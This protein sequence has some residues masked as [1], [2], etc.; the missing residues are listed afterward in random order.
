MLKFFHKARRRAVNLT[1]KLR[2]YFN[3][4]TKSEAILN[5]RRSEVKARIIRSRVKDLFLEQ[6]NREIS[7]FKKG[8]SNDKLYQ[9][10][11]E[12]ADKIA[13]RSESNVSNIVF[14]FELQRNYTPKSRK[15][16]VQA[17]LRVLK[18]FSR[19]LDKTSSDKNFNRHALVSACFKN[20]VELVLWTANELHHNYKRTNLFQALNLRF[21]NRLICHLI[22]AVDNTPSDVKKMEMLEHLN[23]TYRCLDFENLDLERYLLTNLAK[24][25]RRS[26]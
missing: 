15:A 14:N 26:G 11:W 19:L 17:A 18:M 5:K 23:Y 12:L 2:N 20:L 8:I 25:K 10:L 16:Y 1:A 24:I 21:I 3:M 9:R 4:L 13:G 6:V 7:D 22:Q